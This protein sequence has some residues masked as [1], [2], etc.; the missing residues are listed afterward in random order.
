MNLKTRVARLHHDVVMR[1]VDLIKTLDMNAERTAANSDN[2]IIK[3][4][5]PGSQSEVLQR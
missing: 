1:E 2:R 4:L 5:I 3:L